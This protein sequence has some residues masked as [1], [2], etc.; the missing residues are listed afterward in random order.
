MTRQGLIIIL[1][2]LGII[3]LLSLGKIL[4]RP[5]DQLDYCDFELLI[6][7][8]GGFI[9]RG[10][11]GSVA[12]FISEHLAVNPVAVVRTFSLL[13][14][15]TVGYYL[16]SSFYKNRISILYLLMPFS[17]FFLLLDERLMFRDFFLHIIFILV[18]KLLFRKEGISKYF[19][20][21]VVVSFGTLV[22]EMFFFF[23]LPL[24]FL[25]A[26]KL[27][28]KYLIKYLLLLLPAAVFVLIIKKHGTPEAA[29]LVYNKI[30]T[31]LPFSSP[32]AMPL[33]IVALGSEAELV[34]DEV[35]LTNSIGFSRGIL[36]ILFLCSLYFT[37]LR[38]SHFDISIGFF[39]AD[40]Y[41]DKF[42]VV[43]FFTIQIISCFPLM[44]I[45]YDWQRF[46]N[47]ALISSIIV[48]LEYHKSSS[49]T[50]PTNISFK[51]IKDYSAKLEGVINRF[52]KN[53]KHITITLSFFILIPHLHLGKQW[54]LFNNAFLMIPDYLSKILF[55]LAE[56]YA[57]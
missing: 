54:Y 51:I 5:L 41:L 57:P 26:F 43:F 27:N 42:A 22:H 1:S 53:D 12:L 45:A 39:K 14:F 33:S 9:R 21:A 3:Y 32:S 23:S 8:S 35:F 19:Y 31:V 38:L 10:L 46:F 47:F 37:V 11:I 7:Y 2:F 49:K 4:L 52:I 25:Y 29:L 20:L 50:L 6:N 17:Y 44:M 56:F 48:S 18:A 30:L 15:V 16:F 24:I 13:S 55:S 40:N 28:K 34:A 36:Y